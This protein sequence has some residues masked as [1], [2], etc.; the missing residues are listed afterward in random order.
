MSRLPVA[1]LALVLFSTPAQSQQDGTDPATCDASA[2]IIDLAD[3]LLV[4]PPQKPNFWRD[5]LGSD[6]AFLKIV[7]G[8]LDHDAGKAL[9]LDL[10]KRAKPPE[11]IVE[12]RIAQADPAERAAMLSALAPDTFK[13]NAALPGTSGWRGQ[14]AADGG[15]WLLGELKR[16]REAEPASFSSSGIAASLAR[17]LTGL[18]D[19]KLADFARRAEAEGL[20]PVALTVHAARDILADY[21]AMLDRLPP[22]AIQGSP[23]EARE[24][25]LRYAMTFTDLRADFDMDKQP[26]A[27]KQAYARRSYSALYAPFGPL[28]AQA[29]EAGFLLTVINQ[30][31]ETRV[32]TEL[33]AGLLADIE[34]GKLDARKNPDTV[35]VTAIAGLDRI[36]GRQQR[37]GVLASF[38]PATPSGLQG[39]VMT[40]VADQAVARLALAPFVAGTAEEPARPELLTKTFEW[41]RWL[42][43]AKAARATGTIAANDRLI[44][45]DILAAAGK[46]GEALVLFMQEQDW[47]AAG[48]QAHV[49]ALQ[50]DRRCASRLLHPLPLNE[51]LYRFD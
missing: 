43:V 35:V 6:A 14:V 50:L 5:R 22:E 16:W 45:A 20:W 21:V 1:L 41:D 42:G 26:T 24:G 13:A 17:S 9:I 44:A 33:A 3:F 47:Q 48:R 18:P 37:E 4:D 25:W 49:L 28:L 38:S 15:D 40:V 10:E 51:T 2:A 31:G 8:G 29:P 12:L 34:A 27:L 46:P 11:R 19:N 39:E 32:G 36:F 7:Y 23:D 30:T